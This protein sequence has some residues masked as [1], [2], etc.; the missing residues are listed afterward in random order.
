[1]SDEIVMM[2]VREHNEQWEVTLL[3][4]RGRFIVQAKN[5]GGDNNT[6]VDLRDLIAWLRANRPELLEPEP[7]PPPHEPSAEFLLGLLEGVD[8]P[9]TDKA[10][11][12]DVTFE[13]RDGWKVVIF[14]DCGGLDYI[15]SFIDPAGNTLNWW[16]DVDDPHDQSEDASALRNWRGHN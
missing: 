13:C 11:A 9:G 14:Y 16:W 15:D 5:A 1:M 6:R 12:C 3:N 4:E 7:E 10:D 2:G 8:I